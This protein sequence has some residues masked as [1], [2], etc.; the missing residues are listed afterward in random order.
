MNK[1]DNVLQFKK[2]SQDVVL[3]GSF[4]DL[5]EARENG[6]NNERNSSGTT[7]IPHGFFRKINEFG[8]IEFFGCFIDGELK[9]KCWKSVTGGKI[10]TDL[11][12]INESITSFII[13]NHSIFN[14]KSVL[15]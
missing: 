10:L 6:R 5:Q 2:E 3:E 12:L 8:E 7:W 1:F 13:F 15:F 4:K 14:L 11:S 9:G